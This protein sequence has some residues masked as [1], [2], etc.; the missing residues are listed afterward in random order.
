MFDWNLFKDTC[1]YE[2]PK[3]CLC[4]SL[5]FLFLVI[6]HHLDVGSRL[7]RLFPWQMVMDCQEVFI[8]CSTT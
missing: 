8:I 7:K 2:L 4:F 3:I 5:F 6:V 1:K